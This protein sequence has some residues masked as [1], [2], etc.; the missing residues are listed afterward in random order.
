MPA[1]DLYLMALSFPSP[2]LSSPLLSRPPLPPLSSLPLSSPPSLSLSLEVG[3]PNPARGSG[4]A[5]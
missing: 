1:S 2:S 5:L 4:G 3:P